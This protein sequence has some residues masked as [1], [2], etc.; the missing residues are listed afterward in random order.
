MSV[1]ISQE[2]EGNVRELKNAIEH[3]VAMAAHNK[4]IPEDLP[5]HIYQNRISSKNMSAQNF[6]H[7][8]FA[9]AKEEFEKS[10]IEGLIKNCNGDVTKAANISQIKR[11]NIYDKFK[12]YHIDINRY[13]KN[14]S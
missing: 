2:W 14:N 11:Q 8:P 12:K 1:L 9:E 5:D 10:Y 7:L 3:A 13:R 6:M 4:I